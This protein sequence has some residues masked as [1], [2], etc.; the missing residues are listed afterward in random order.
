M[1]IERQNKIPQSL[2]YLK[3]INRQQVSKGG[4][5]ENETKRIGMTK[6]TSATLEK[7][8]KDHGINETTSD[9]NT[10]ISNCHLQI[11]VMDR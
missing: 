10:D 6:N 5:C 1:I 2:Q 7:L 4:Q 9:F 11:R 3:D 8:W